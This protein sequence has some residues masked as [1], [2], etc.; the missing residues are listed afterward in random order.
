[1]FDAANFPFTKINCGLCD[2]MHCSV[3]ALRR[4]YV[5]VHSKLCKFQKNNSNYGFQFTYINLIS[6]A[7]IQQ[8]AEL[9]QRKDWIKTEFDRE[10]IRLIKLG[11]K[12]FF[13]VN[14]NFKSEG[15]S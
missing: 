15:A 14:K 2:S 13:F 12:N 10:L 11:K 5:L 4:H 1:M 6:L 7:T 3:N 9:I 8:C